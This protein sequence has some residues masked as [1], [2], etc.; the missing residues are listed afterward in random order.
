MAIFSLLVPR[1]CRPEKRQGA[2][3]R[4]YLIATPAGPVTIP[5]G[6]TFDGYTGCIVVAMQDPDRV[7][8]GCDG[9]LAIVRTIRAPAGQFI[10][11]C[12]FAEGATAAG[13]IVPE[14]VFTD[15][16]RFRLFGPGIAGP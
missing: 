13:Y 3:G 2:G 12:T 7:A 10:G 16:R 14:A 4:E 6:P 9:A 5:N 1:L 11:A 8:R 15:A